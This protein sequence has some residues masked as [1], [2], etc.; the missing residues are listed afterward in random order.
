MIVIKCN[1]NSKIMIIGF[2][3]M[4]K[5]TINLINHTASSFGR[6]K[7]ELEQVFTA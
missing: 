6:L 1:L 7:V 2:P 5:D 4:N 3:I